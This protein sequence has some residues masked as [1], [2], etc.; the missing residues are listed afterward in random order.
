MLAGAALLLAALWL[1][2]GSFGITRWIAGALGVL[3]LALAWT[4][5][6]RIRFGR[7]VGDGPGVVT[8]DER[9][10]AYWG[11]LTGGVVDLDNLL[12]LDLDPSGEPSHWVLTP[13]KGDPLAVPVT[14]TGAEAL[15]DLFTALPGLRVETLIAALDRPRGPPVTLWMLPNVVAFP[16]SGSRRRLH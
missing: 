10:L 15:L 7:G 12:R 11:P 5:F 14:A 2:L 9:R 4:G 16:A 6:Q 3:G 8:V 13:I 1:G